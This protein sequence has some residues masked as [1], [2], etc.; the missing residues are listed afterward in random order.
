MIE[1]KELHGQPLYIWISEPGQPF[2][3][4]FVL[5]RPDIG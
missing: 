2:Q 3:S 1:V 5:C 4:Q